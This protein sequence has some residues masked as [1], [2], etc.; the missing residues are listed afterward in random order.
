MMLAAAALAVVALGPVGAMER[1]S[2]LPLE[3]TF[4]FTLGGA[5]SAALL[6]KWQKTVTTYPLRGCGNRTRTRTIY[7]QPGVVPAGVD[8]TG[9]S[10]RSTKAVCNSFGVQLIVDAVSYPIRGGH[11]GTEWT[12]EFRNTG[13]NATLP[14]CAVQ[15]LNATLPMHRGANLTVC[16]RGRAICAA[17]SCLGCRQ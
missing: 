3:S 10:Q 13:P 16:A 5:P 4:S 2:G 11:T 8:P 1:L 14:L 6:P 15:T 9:C 17:C 7:F 12:L